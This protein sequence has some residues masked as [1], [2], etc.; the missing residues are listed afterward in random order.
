MCLKGATTFRILIYVVFS[1]L[2]VHQSGGDEISK[3]WLGTWKGEGF[4]TPTEKGD[5]TKIRDTWVIAITNESGVLKGTLSR[6]F[7]FKHSGYSSVDQLN[8]EA[9][10]WMSKLETWGPG[11]GKTEV[12]R[13]VAQTLEVKFNSRGDVLKFKIKCEG[14]E[15]DQQI[16]VFYW[17]KDGKNNL[18]R[19]L[20]QEEANLESSEIVAKIKADLPKNRL[21]AVLKNVGD[22]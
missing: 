17:F 20:S 11:A 9:K 14:A 10:S 16:K 8:T 3:N 7:S 19:L 4:G 15:P 5:D 21:R 22:F 12:T 13:G 2:G 1:V 6:V 18:Y